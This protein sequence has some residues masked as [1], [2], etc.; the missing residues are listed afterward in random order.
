MQA[1]A[2][3]LRV[4]TIVVPV[5]NEA[6]RI[7][8]ALD[9]LVK[10]ELPLQ[11]EILVV[12]DGSSD[13][14]SELISDLVESGAINLIR[15]ERNRGKGAAVRT[16]IENASGDLLTICDADLE[17][18]PDDYAK[19]LQPILDGD[20][21]VVY[22]TRTFGAHTAFSFW[23]VLGNRVVNLW[24]SFLFNTWLSDVETCFK[25]APV[26]VWRSLGIKSNG[27]GLEAE[28]TGKILRTGHVIYEV[29]ISY[30]ARTRMQ[31]KKLQWTD[32]VAALWI[33]LRQRLKR[34]PRQPS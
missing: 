22:G 14:S 1:G 8:P 2:P 31:G 29:P 16:G 6:E 7:R 17:Y 25:M 20:T 23:Y 33:L 11:T 18:D 24:A 26:E 34:A 30:R 28:A 19:L 3:N 5:Y 13:G 9:R 10:T 32:G 21:Q 27:F 12:D 4:L 15:H